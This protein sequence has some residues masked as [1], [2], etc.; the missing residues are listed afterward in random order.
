VAFQSGKYTKAHK[1]YA[2]IK[3]LRNA[4]YQFAW[5]STKEAWALE[6]CQRKRRAGKSHSVALRSL[7]KEWVRLIHAIWRNEHPSNEAIFRAAQ[8]AHARPAA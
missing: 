4:L 3:P 8:E 7:A 1:R 6:H 2:C 5:Q